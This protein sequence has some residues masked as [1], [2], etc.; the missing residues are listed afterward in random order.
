MKSL[1]IGLKFVNTYNT[2]F[3]VV[4]SFNMLK[5]SAYHNYWSKLGN[6]LSRCSKKRAKHRSYKEYCMSFIWSNSNA[7]K[8]LLKRSTWKGICAENRNI[9]V[10]LVIQVNYST[11]ILLSKLSTW[12]GTWCAET[13]QKYRGR[14]QPRVRIIFFLW[15]RG[16]HQRNLSPPMVHIPNS[17]QR[18]K[19]KHEALM[20]MLR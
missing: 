16:L 14:R 1:G 6:I 7:I 20:F 9:I 13:K 2:L 18:N 5:E 10:M 12:K 8:L 3:G 17:V 19:T 4:Q 11:I 15:S